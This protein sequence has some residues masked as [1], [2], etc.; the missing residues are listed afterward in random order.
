MENDS[1]KVIFRAKVKIFLNGGGIPLESYQIS[2]VITGTNL[3]RVINV[4]TPKGM[5][6][7]PPKE[8]I[9]DG[10]NRRDSANFMI[11]ESA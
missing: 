2:P 7:R 3:A 9:E 4:E 11:N 6:F 1:L 8:T 10:L 5:M